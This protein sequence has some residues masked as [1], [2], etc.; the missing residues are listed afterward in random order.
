MCTWKTWT[1]EHW[2]LI[3]QSFKEVKH[4]R[5]NEH[6]YNKEE[7]N[8]S[9]QMQDNLCQ[10]STSS[11]IPFWTVQLSSVYLMFH[12]LG[13]TGL[14]QLPLSISL[15]C[16]SKTQQSICSFQLSWKC[17][18]FFRAAIS[19]LCLLAVRCVCARYVYVWVYVVCV[20]ACVH[21]CVKERGNN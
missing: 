6:G 17:L 11:G 7:I 10:Y 4:L 13:F 2:L 19:M 14:T 16:I 5:K 15:L 1:N 21:G 8:K 18:V 9:A 12:D 20:H 3:I